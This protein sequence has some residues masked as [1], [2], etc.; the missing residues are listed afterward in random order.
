MTG[1]PA[2]II[3]GA[4][5]FLVFPSVGGRPLLTVSRKP[6]CQGMFWAALRATMTANVQA[7]GKRQ[8]LSHRQT[9]WRHSALSRLRTW[10]AANRI[11]PGGGTGNEAVGPPNP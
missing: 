1:G 10:D 6:G 4:D 11:G 7:R 9:A 2:K 8:L 5:G 3:A